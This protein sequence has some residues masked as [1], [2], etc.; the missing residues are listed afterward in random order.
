MFINLITSYCRQDF[1]RRVAET[2]PL[3]VWKPYQ[4]ER[5]FFQSS[6]INVISRKPSDCPGLGH[7]TISVARTF[8][9]TEIERPDA[10]VQLASQSTANRRFVL[11][12]S[13]KLGIPHNFRMWRI[14]SKCPHFLITH[15][16]LHYVPIANSGSTMRHTTVTNP[17]HPF[18]VLSVMCH[19]K[20][21][22]I[23]K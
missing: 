12:P 1:P 23:L 21:L 3:R 10:Q 8:P 6:K 15:Q 2:R 18:H 4:K 11:F 7:M 13:C 17:G 19:Q 16:P 22:F 5:R 20:P 14:L 9:R